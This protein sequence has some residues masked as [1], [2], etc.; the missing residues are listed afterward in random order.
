MNKKKN[1]IW[2]ASYPKSGNTWFRVFLC[3]LLSE[4]DEPVNINMLNRTSIASN[5]I[6]FDEF[7]GVHSA[8]LTFE[9]IEILRPEVYKRISEESEYDVFLKTHDAWKLNAAGKPLFPAENTK[10]VIYFLRNPLDIAVSFTFHL[11]GSFDQ[12]IN[13][14]NQ[15]DFGFCLKQTKLYNQIPQHMFSWSGHV[16]SWIYDSGLPIHIMKYED[17]LENTYKT[18]KNALDFIHIDSTKPE[19]IAALNNS[20]FSKLASQEKETGFQEKNIN[21]SKFFRN[22]TKN[23]WVKYLNKK[24]IEQFINQNRSIMEKFGYLEEIPYNS[25]H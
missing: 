1:I 22:G 7:L 14:M 20:A 12:T 16:N 18:F 11:G 13:Y 19:I 3:N 6:L 10:G 9:E 24:Q 23:N 21:S 2:L 5:R 25:T 17:M 8:D 15:Q 4:A